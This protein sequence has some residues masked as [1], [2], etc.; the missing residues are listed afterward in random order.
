LERLRFNLLEKQ[1]FH[2]PIGADSPTLQSSWHDLGVVE[3]HQVVATK[4]LRQIAN[5]PMLDSLARPMHHDHARRIARLDGPRGD[6]FR[7]KFVLEFFSAQGQMRLLCNNQVSADVVCTQQP[8]QSESPDQPPFESILP[9]GDVKSYGK[10][11]G[12]SGGEGLWRGS[13]SSWCVSIGRPEHCTQLDPIDRLIRV[14]QRS[15][16]RSHCAKIPCAPCRINCI[17]DARQCR[18]IVDALQREIGRLIRRVDRFDL[19]GNN[20]PIAPHVQSKNE[21]PHLLQPSNSLSASR[22]KPIYAAP[23]LGMSLSS[24]N[25]PGSSQLMTSVAPAPRTLIDI[26][27]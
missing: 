26:L 19:C 5:V 6:Q 10:L 18:I 1:T 2:A 24:P 11:G 17:S 21:R 7:R 20:S 8:R 12:F 16:K 9:A 3:H 4:I 27:A 23:P 13:C 14:H 15:L 22:S 25:Q